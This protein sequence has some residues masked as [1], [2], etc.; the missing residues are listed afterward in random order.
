MEDKKPRISMTGAI[1]ILSISILFAASTISSAIRE[2]SRNNVD[3]GQYHVQYLHQL[4]MFNSN[5]EEYLR[6]INNQ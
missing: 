3:H 5:F 1:I 2:A 6:D 4:E